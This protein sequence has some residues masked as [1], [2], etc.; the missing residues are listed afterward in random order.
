M[1]MWLA[2]KIAGA[3][4]PQ[5]EDTAMDVGVTT[6]GGKEVAVETRGE[7]RELPVYAPGGVYWQP[8]AG[9]AV[10][11]FKGGVGGEDRCVLA[12]E[13]KELTVKLSPGEM[14]LWIGG[15]YLRL[16][17]DGSLELNGMININGALFINGKPFSAG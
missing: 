11:V 16:H 1:T 8:A 7:D 12:A 2:K 14:C 17:E 13:P 4:A 10:L 5:E 3:D 9:D 15:S 6:I